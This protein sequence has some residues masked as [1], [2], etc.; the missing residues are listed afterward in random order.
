MAKLDKV[1]QEGVAISVEELQEGVTSIAAPVWDEKHR[2]VIA[3]IN[4]AGPTQRITS[5]KIPVLAKYVQQAS[6]KLSGT[7]WSA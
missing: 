6:A 5:D 3:A 4:I 2:K 1:R 7:H